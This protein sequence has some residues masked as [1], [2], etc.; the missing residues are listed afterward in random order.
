MKSGKPSKVRNEQIAS[1]NKDNPNGSGH[2]NH[3]R[4]A[5]TAYELYEKRGRVDGYDLDDWL[6]AE[7]H[8]SARRD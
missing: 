5:Q 2:E 8:L 3:R 6:K 1:T 4:V 7:A